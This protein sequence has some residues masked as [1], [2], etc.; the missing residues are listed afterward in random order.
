ML[1]PKLKF[2]DVLQV[3]DKTRLD[4]SQSYV[5]KDEVAL[6]SVEIDPGDGSGFISVFDT[7]YL[8]WYLDFEY[9]TEG[10]KTVTVRVDNGSGPITSSFSITVLSVA[11]D[12]LFSDDNDLR[13]IKH[14]ILKWLPPGKSSFNYAH[15][16]AQERIVAIFDEKG[17]VDKDGNKLTKAAFV[18][19]SEAKEAS[20]FLTLSYIFE[21]I[22]DTIDDIHG[23]KSIKYFNDFEKVFQRPWRLDIDGD[24]V[25]DVGEGIR[26]FETVKLQRFR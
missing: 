14:D 3:N 25:L 17:I 18:D 16:R 20:T 5:S 21:D 1:F 2:E 9:A 15:R 4:A 24:A 12:K 11:D 19:V 23:Q 26:P 8:D 7:N 22:S 13:S 10:V 6:T